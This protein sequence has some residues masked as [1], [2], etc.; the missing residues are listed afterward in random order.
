MIVFYSNGIRPFFVN[1]RYVKIHSNGIK[2]FN[3]NNIYIYLYRIYMAINYM[4]ICLL[5]SA[6]METKP[7]SRASTLPYCLS[8]KGSLPEKQLSLQ[9]RRNLKLQQIWRKAF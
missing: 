7:A 5:L 9:S 1:N 8:G 3:V 4:V 6:R 2:P